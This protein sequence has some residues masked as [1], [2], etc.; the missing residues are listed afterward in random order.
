MNE[1]E[2]RLSKQPHLHVYDDTAVGLCYLDTNLRYLHIN[3][4]LAGLNGIP[5]EKHLG[6]I[7]HEVIPE[8]A[9]GVEAQLR[10]VIETNTPILE[11]TVEAETPAQPG[12]R[13][14][15]MHSY[16]P[17]T[18]ENGKIV[19]VSC[20]VQDITDRRTAEVAL[21]QRVADLHQTTLELEAAN[22][23]LVEAAR[24]RNR[25][26]AET[27]YLQ[28]DLNREHLFEEIVGKSG[29]MMAT[30]HKV[31][32]AAKTDATVLLLGETGTGKEMLA[33]ALHA[34]SN[35]SHK[36]L[37]RIDC[38]TLPPGLIESELFGH[39]KGAFTG[40]HESKVGRFE[41]AD[42]GTIFLDEI[43]ELPV[44]LQAKLLRVL[45][46]GEFQ[47]LG[48][49]RGHRVDVRIIA[50]TNRD[51]R[52]EM[53]EGRFRADL[54]YRLS[55]F[56]IE[57]PP[58]RE[59]REDI[60]LLASY[61]LSKS[62]AIVGKKIDAIAKSSMDALVAYDWPGNIREL[63]NVI[64]R[65][66][67]L[68]SGTTLTVKEALGDFEFRD[69]EPARSLKQDLEEIERANILRALEGSGWKIKGEG[70]AAGRLGMN[71]NTLR[72]RIKTLGISR[73]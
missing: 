26:E 33:R 39:E 41:L 68:C 72:S 30:L 40:A 8:V 11:G 34:G 32:Q 10:Q 64:E 25:L 65:S 71:P 27:E 13:R 42:N 15:F 51:L 49:K 37:V 53:R 66:A 9:S 44:D 3:K 36:P 50:A 17:V 73:L 12:V 7:I 59:R 23:K 20:L 14:T 52:N 24:A 6:R 55:V 16:L 63:Q 54:Y 5:V 45:Q 1:P 46:D 57:S 4:W 19:G 35:R 69:R 38:T 56:P 47:R 62:R 48:S 28:E 58:L 61:F 22:R 67:I 70:N 29:A 2:K 60:P 21:K 18:A 43:G 31:A